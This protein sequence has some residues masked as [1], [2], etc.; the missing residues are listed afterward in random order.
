MFLS[1]PNV[2]RL[3][4]MRCD[5]DV[6]VPSLG[7]RRGG[8][9]V[10][11]RGDGWGGAAAARPPID[12]FSAPCRILR[13]GPPPRAQRPAS[14]PVAPSCPSH[15]YGSLLLGRGGAGSVVGV[16]NQRPR[17]QR[18]RRVRLGRAVVGPSLTAGGWLLWSWRTGGA[19][20]SARGGW[21]GG[22]RGGWGC[23][24]VASV[25]G[26]VEDRGGQVAMGWP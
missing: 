25:A 21:P 7:S 16:G 18:A 12:F 26:R 13:V 22:R 20:Q 1:P 23:S 4:A 10:A 5:G 19:H 14:A 2:Q 9:T 3:N 11:R 6:S 15:R 24:G 8:G 17:R